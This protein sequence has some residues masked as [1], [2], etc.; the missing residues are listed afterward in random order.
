MHLKHKKLTFKI[1][2]KV[3]VVIAMLALGFTANAQKNVIKANPLGLAFGVGDFSYERV[4]SDNQAFEIGLSFASA[5]VT[6]GSEVVSSSA[7]G[8]EGCISFIFLLQKTLLEDGML[9]LS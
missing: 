4:V 5:K 7:I 8:G 9:H 6:S 1:M 3:L 2:K